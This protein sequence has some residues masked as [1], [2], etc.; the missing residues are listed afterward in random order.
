[1]SRY[2]YCESI[3]ELVDLIV[4]RVASCMESGKLQFGNLT[5]KV[6]ELPSSN[7]AKN[8]SQEELA[9][10]FY[11]AIGAYGVTQAFLFDIE[12]IQLVMG[13]YGSDDGIQAVHFARYDEFDEDEASNRISYAIHLLLSFE[14]SSISSTLVEVDW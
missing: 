7:E 1:M 2:V 14:T 10:G 13:Y 9:E 12:G 3:Q 6:D 11:N 8:M 4:K 5:F